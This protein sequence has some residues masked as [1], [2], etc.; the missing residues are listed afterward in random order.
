M[1][2]KY[3]VDTVCIYSSC[4]RYIYTFMQEFVFQSEENSGAGSNFLKLPPLPVAMNVISSVIFENKIYISGTRE[5]DMPKSCQIHVYS[6]KDAA[7]ST[8][9][10]API[11]NAD[12]VFVNDQITLLGG[13]AVKTDEPTDIVWSWIEKEGRWG[14][15]MLSPMPRARMA[16]AVCHYGNI[17]IVAGG[18]VENGTDRTAVNRVDVYNFTSQ[19]WNTP[20][21]LQLPEARRSHF[22]VCFEGYIYATGG[23]S[24]FHEDS[25]FSCNTWRVKC[26]DLEKAVQFPAAMS[27][28]CL[29]KPT[30]D[31]PVL[32]STVV[33]CE[34]SILSVGGMKDRKP[35]DVIYRLVR[36]Q[37]G[38]HWIKVGNMN[39]GKFRHAVVPLG[40]HTLFVAGGYVWDEYDLCERRSASVEVVAL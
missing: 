26:T 36:K 33:S 5:D 13:C 10:E 12:I 39:I 23:S 21:E 19:Q 28:K 11:Y 3:T 32:R 7:W 30:T 14:H 16:I 22:L 15:S 24:S 6:L 27:E 17:L 29:W 1:V 2:S 40:S 31:L 20:P 8:L 38:N 34:T 37:D 25:A 9:P 18:A 4:N 35:Q